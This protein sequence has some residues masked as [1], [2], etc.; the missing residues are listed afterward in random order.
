VLYYLLYLPHRHIDEQFAESESGTSSL[1]KKRLSKRI[2]KRSSTAQKSA[3][4]GSPQQPA[5]QSTGGFFF[6]YFFGN[7]APEP[8]AA[9][10]NNTMEQ[11]M[12]AT[13]TAT[14]HTSNAASSLAANPLHQAP[15]LS[16]QS[17]PSMESGVPSGVQVLNDQ[18]P[19][20][21]SSRKAMT[22]EAVNLLLDDLGSA[23]SDLMT[24]SRH[25]QSNSV[26][27]TGNSS[28]G[29]SSSSSRSRIAAD[30]SRA[31]AISQGL[32]SVDLDTLLDREDRS[33]VF[34][35]LSNILCMHASVVL[36]CSLREVSMQ[37]DSS[38]A[39]NVGGRVLTVSDMSRCL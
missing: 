4:A 18:A 29:T 23:F 10:T 6:D 17:F 7:S 22:S 24:S 25:D 9:P 12:T 31:S 36:Q 30:L 14:T 1:Q 16:A 2:S 15:L 32:A 39:Y 38:V 21:S 8:T 37:H 28:N 11:E 19:P 5:A 26:S 20:S 34:M 3:A 13:T 35:R 27:G 33:E